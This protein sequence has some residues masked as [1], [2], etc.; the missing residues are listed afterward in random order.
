MEVAPKSPTHC[1]YEATIYQNVTKNELDDDLWSKYNYYLVRHGTIR[2]LHESWITMWYRD[3]WPSV[4]LIPVG[5]AFIGTMS[6]QKR[7]NDKKQRQSW[8]LKGI[9][10][11]HSGMTGKWV[12]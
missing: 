11:D 5:C 7:D 9:F 12:G 2:G 10:F 3:K 1:A 6:I 8:M 4:S